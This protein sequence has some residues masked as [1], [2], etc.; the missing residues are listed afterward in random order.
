MATSVPTHEVDTIVLI[1]GLWMTPL[2]WEHWSERL[3]GRGYRVIAPSWPGMERGIDQLRRDPESIAGVGVTE[4][5]DHYAKILRE[6]RT[7]PILMGHSFGGAFVQLLLDRGLGAAGV[8]IHSAPVRG[9]YTLNLSTLKSTFPILGNPTNVRRAVALTPKQFHYAFTNTLT[10]HDSAAVYDRYHSPGPGRVLFQAALANLNPRAPTRVNF[11]RNYRAPL[12][13][14]AGGSD[15]LV[16]AAVNR[17]NARR[18]TSNAVTEFIEFAGRS[19]YTLGQAGWEE[20]ADY[21]LDW[22]VA[23]ATRV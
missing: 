10:E 11:T 13:L 6:L 20:V 17:E 16:P 18:Y 14:I 5:L 22:A 23:H 8:A 19:H 21:A 3:S 15:H 9:V 7:A 4:I 2:S 12:L 1:H